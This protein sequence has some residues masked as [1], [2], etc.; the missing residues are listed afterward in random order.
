MKNCINLSSLLENSI[1]IYLQLN[2]K[3]QRYLKLSNKLLKFCNKH[4][5][6]LLYDKIKILEIQAKIL[7]VV[8][9]FFILL[10]YKL[11]LIIIEKLQD[12]K[13]CT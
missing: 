6:R 2:N 1:F 9:L 8:D 10:Q 3:L 11:L 4:K 7:K 12:S 13:N 5:K